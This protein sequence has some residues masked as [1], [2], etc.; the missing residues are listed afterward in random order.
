MTTLLV[1]FDAQR[2]LSRDAFREYYRSEHAPI[3]AELPHLTA[4]EVIFPNDPDRAPFDGVAILEFPDR[5]RFRGAMTSDA[6][7]AMEADADAFV[8]PESL[9]QLVGEAEDM[10]DAGSG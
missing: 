5:E 2:D 6:A 10:L 8:A 9:T 4:Y 3:V 1:A 7:D